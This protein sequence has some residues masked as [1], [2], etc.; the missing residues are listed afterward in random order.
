MSDL[1][2]LE[3]HSS[4]CV[5]VILFPT[6]RKMLKYKGKAICLR[7]GIFPLDLVLTRTIILESV[8]RVG[9]RRT[10]MEDP[11]R[12]DGAQS[13]EVCGEVFLCDR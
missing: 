13:E 12:H 2:R 6:S 3:L 11:D 1:R 7:G 5:Y 9:W 10:L 4:R 8:E